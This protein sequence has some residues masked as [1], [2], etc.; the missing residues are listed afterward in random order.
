MY[1]GNSAYRDKATDW[2]TGVHFPDGAMMG[3]SLFA[4]AFKPILW[5][6]QPP[7]QWWALSPGVKWPRREA[8]RPHSAEVKNAWSYTC[9]PP[10]RVGIF[11]TRHRL[12]TGSGPPQAFHPMG[13]VGFCPGGTATGA[14]SWL[15]LH[16]VPRLRMRWAV[17]PLLQYVF[18][19]WC[20]INHRDYFAFIVR[21]HWVCYLRRTDSTIRRVPIHP[22]ARVFLCVFS[23]P[24]LP[25]LSAT[26]L[27]ALWVLLRASPTR[28]YVTVE[29][30]WE[31]R[32]NG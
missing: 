11:S 25:L 1:V 26:V 30:T 18:M 21:S 13:A 2:T 15:H 8:D 31:T 5:L 19:A 32:K 24:L 20:V 22:G 16:L 4:A 28:I 29:V 27:P 23:L 14:W 6:T 12:Q 3:F 9:T 10:A 17:P 7:V